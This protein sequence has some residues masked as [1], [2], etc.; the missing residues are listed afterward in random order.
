MHGYLSC[1]IAISVTTTSQEVC[2]IFIRNDVC[3]SQV[4]IILPV[5][6]II[7]HL[8]E[9]IMSHRFGIP[10]KTGSA[11]KV[12]THTLVKT[13]TSFF[14]VYQHFKPPDDIVQM[15]VSSQFSQDMR[16]MQL[17]IYF[18]N[19]AVWI[20]SVRFYWTFLF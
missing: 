8:R 3:V 9:E 6:Q 17:A 16:T 11:T 13:T 10:T 5:N 18:S 7:P 15:P 1:N 12:T 4:T 19:K 14:A 2:R 20:V